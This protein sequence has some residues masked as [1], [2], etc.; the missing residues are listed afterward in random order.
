[1]SEANKPNIFQH[2]KKCHNLSLSNHVMFFYFLNTYKKQ[3]I[4]FLLQ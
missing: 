4:Y 2:E 3:N 1:M